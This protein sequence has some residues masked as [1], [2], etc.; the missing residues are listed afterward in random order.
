MNSWGVVPIYL[1]EIAPPAFRAS[2]AGVAYQ[3][4]NMVSSAAAQIEARG[5]ENIKLKG[6]NTPDYAT[7]Q[8]ILI[9]CVIAWMMVFV[10]LGPEAQSAHFEQA[11]VAVQR[12]AG[13]VVGRDLMDKHPRAGEHVEDVRDAHVE[14]ARPNEIV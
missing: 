2:F 1:S 6:T 9:G 4:G 14:K 10:V 13:K 5:G 3:L 7:V 8:G 11:K 12:G